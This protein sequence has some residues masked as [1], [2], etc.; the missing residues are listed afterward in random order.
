MR[1]YHNLQFILLSLWI[2]LVMLCLFTSLHDYYINVRGIRYNSSKGQDKDK[3]TTLLSH[4]YHNLQ[5]ILLSLWI[6][7]VML[8]LFT[9]L[10][11]YYINVLGALGIIQV[12]D[13]TE[14]KNHPS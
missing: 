14:I 9:S 10:H 5:F 12:K 8:C 4:A 2:H 1:L 7:L 6:H 11:D 3:K 13:K